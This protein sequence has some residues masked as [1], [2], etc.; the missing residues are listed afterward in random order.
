[1]QQEGAIFREPKLV[2][3]LFKNTADCLK[4]GDDFTFNDIS[5]LAD[6][7]YKS[8][9][10]MDKNYSDLIIDQLVQSNLL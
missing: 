9:M 1:M 2:E 5:I 10:Q 4:N 8:Q 3:Y 6:C 7:Q